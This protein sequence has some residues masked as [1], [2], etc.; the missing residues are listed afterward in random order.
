MKRKIGYN[1]IHYPIS[2]ESMLLC[3]Y[4]VKN[5]IIVLKSDKNFAFFEPVIGF[6]LILFIFYC[7]FNIQRFSTP[8]P[9]TGVTFSKTPMRELWEKWG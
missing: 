2:C 9:F 4:Y 8:S 6:F 1:V 3:N 7:P 5:Q